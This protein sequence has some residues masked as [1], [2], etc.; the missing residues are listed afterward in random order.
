M[1]L[2][3]H[4]L[5]TQI[6]NWILLRWPKIFCTFNTWSFQSTFFKATQVPERNEHSTNAAHNRWRWGPSSKQSW[7]HVLSKQQVR[8]RKA[9]QVFTNTEMFLWKAPGEQQR[10]MNKIQ[11]KKPTTSTLEMSPKQRWFSLLPGQ[12]LPSNWLT[13]PYGNESPLQ[14]SLLPSHHLI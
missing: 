9:G 14:H 13:L 7:P 12:K 6:P 3:P 4:A 8:S 5:I 2:H 1:F 11:E 10:I